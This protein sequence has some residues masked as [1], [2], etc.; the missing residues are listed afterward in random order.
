MQL[1]IK[2]QKHCICTVMFQNPKVGNSRRICYGWSPSLSWRALLTYP[3]ELS[4]GLRQR[5]LIAMALVC[6]PALLIADEPTTALDVTIQAQILKLIRDIQQDLGMSALM[7]THVLGV[8]AN[9][10]DE[11]VVMFHARV[12]EHSTLDDIYSNPGHNYLKAL[13]RAV[14][15]LDMEPGEQLNSLREIK[16]TNGHLLFD[17]PA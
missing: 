3:F 8:V 16:H 15:H 11:I 12:L 6:R 14:P 10:A 5:A 1:A 17:K 7:I 13:L 2:I 9:V 4:G